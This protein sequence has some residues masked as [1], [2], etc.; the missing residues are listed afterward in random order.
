M[1]YKH[2]SPNSDIHIADMSFKDYVNLLK[3]EPESVL[4]AFEGEEK[5]SRIPQ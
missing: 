5:F 1:K 3:S 2:Y 4:Y